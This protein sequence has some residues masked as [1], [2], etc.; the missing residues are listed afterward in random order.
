MSNYKTV[1]FTLG[2]LQIILGLSMSIPIIVQFFFDEFNFSEI[3]LFIF[4]FTNFFKMSFRA[5]RQ[6]ISFKPRILFV[7]EASNRE[8]FGLDA[9]VG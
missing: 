3:V 1:F 5:Y 2:I 9:V 8:K 6:C 4:Y 7:S